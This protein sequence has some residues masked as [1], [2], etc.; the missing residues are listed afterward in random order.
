MRE[1]WD[2]WRLHSW[3]SLGAWLLFGVDVA[4]ARRVVWGL[5]DA[6]VVISAMTT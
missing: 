5:S 6:L 3:L 1:A 2:S 4:F